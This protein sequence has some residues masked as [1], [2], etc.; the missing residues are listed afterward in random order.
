MCS[1]F[2]YPEN[3]KSSYL[4]GIVD[5]L[6]VKSNLVVD[7]G[8]TVLNGTSTIVNTTDL[9][10]KDN[11]IILNRG[12]RGGGTTVPGGI[13][14]ENRQ[15]YSSL[16]NDDIY[17]YFLKTTS[18]PN[19]RTLDPDA[20]EMGEVYANNFQAR[21]HTYAGISNNSNAMET[22]VDEKN[23]LKYNGLGV[24]S[25][26]D[27]ANLNLSTGG[28]INTSN[29]TISSSTT[30]NFT[31][32]GG[33]GNQGFTAYTSGDSLLSLKRNSTGND[34][35][36]LSESTIN[37]KKDVKLETVASSRIL[38]TDSSSKITSSSLSE[39][40]ILTTGANQTI[41]G[42]KTFD[43]K[44]ILNLVNYNPGFLLTT[45]VGTG[46]LVSSQ[47]SF[48]NVV[49]CSTNQTINGIKTFESD[50]VGG[51]VNPQYMIRYPGGFHQSVTAETWTNF[52]CPSLVNSR[53]IT[54]DSTTKNYTVGKNGFYAISFGVRFDDACDRIDLLVRLTRTNSVE[55]DYARISVLSRQASDTSTMLYLDTGESVK[56]MVWYQGGVTN[57]IVAGS[58]ECRFHITYLNGV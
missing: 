37:C 50:I 4:S 47:L 41:T 12:V 2:G 51:L 21:Y 54:Y 30:A 40:D 58:S 14:M 6:E 53:G 22:Y 31:I 27:Y 10:I 57:Y 32:I 46:L 28:N 23:V 15:G 49:D 52:H 44:P 55:L 48:N 11:S 36:S 7:S 29:L 26:I 20:S 42:I 45:Q 33:T 3:V 56:G 18:L 39:S 5:T 19:F 43:V 16:Y 35:L 38:V 1:I 34:I 17:N 25:N 9:E 8:N 24:V 13:I